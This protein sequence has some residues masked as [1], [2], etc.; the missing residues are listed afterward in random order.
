MFARKVA[1]RVKPNSMTR[2]VNLMES[3]ILPWLRKQKGFVDLIVLTA[4]DSEEV[5]TVSFW[6]HSENE[7]A[8][9]STGYPTVL[10]ALG[11]LLEGTPYVKTFDVASSTVHHIAGSRPTETDD[12]VGK[13][14]ATLDYRAC[15]TGP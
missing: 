15:E 5:A 13:I 8:Y 7:E 2:F 11:K 14:S 12:T 4:P 9:N 3:E 1:A 10:K 6:D